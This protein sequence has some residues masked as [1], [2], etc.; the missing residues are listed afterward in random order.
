MAAD[1]GAARTLGRVRTAPMATFTQQEL[2]ARLWEAAN[3]LRGPVDPA[4][5]KSYVFPIL[6]FKWISDTW[7]A[8]HAEAVS[9]FGPDVPPEVE[10]DYHRFTLPDGC[11]WNDV[12]NTTRNIG[13]KLRK[14]LDRIEEANPESLAGIFGDVA[15]GNKE[16]L[17]E[18]ALV[19]LIDTFDKVTLTRE[20]V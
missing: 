17:P 8:E 10:A 9:D 6:F 13:V 3:C 20:H 12:R 11:H 4:D 15:W 5:F 16:R 1:R 14:T 18:H 7:T 2:E 19:N